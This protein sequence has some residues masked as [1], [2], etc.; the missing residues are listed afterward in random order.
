MG[1]K[2]T[3][4]GRVFF[5]S[6]N[7]NDAPKGASLPQGEIQNEIVGLL[8]ALNEKLQA[9]QAERDEIRAELAAQRTKVNQLS[10]KTAYDQEEIS[11]RIHRFEEL[12][13]RQATLEKM[14]LEHQQ[15]LAN[16]SAH[17]VKI[18]RRLEETEQKQDA[19]LVRMEDA[20]AEQARLVRQ[21]DKAVQ[22]RSRMLRKMERIEE[23]VLQTRDA[24]NAGTLRM[25]PDPA[26]PQQAGAADAGMRLNALLGPDPFRHPGSQE[27]KQPHKWWQSGGPQKAAG[28]T[29]LLLGGVLLGWLISDAQMPKMPKFD[30]GIFESLS[31]DESKWEPVLPQ[32]EPLQETALREDVTPAEV[33][34]PQSGAE[35]LATDEDMPEETPA[36]EMS[37]DIAEGEI[38]TEAGPDEAAEDTPDTT[39]LSELAKNPDDELANDIGAIDLKD[40]ASLLAAMENDPEA[41]AAR[42]NEIEPTSLPEREAADVMS[43]AAAKPAPAK[44][45]Q[46]APAVKSSLT[47]LMP[48]DGTLPKVIKDIERQAYEGNAEA[49]H[50][51]AA[52]YTAGHGGVK[53]DYKRAAFWFE[54]A[55]KGGVANARYNLGVLYH[56]GIGVPRDLERALDW[57]KSAADLNHP[58]AQYNL[59]IAYIEGIGLEYDPEK[60]AW[61]F[62]N[63][64][65]A[66]IMEAAYN[67]GL[68]Y[69]NGLLGKAKPDEALMWYK[70]AADAGSPEA[71]A[72]LAQLAKSLNMK[73]EDVNG[74]VEKVEK[75]KNTRGQLDEEKPV[76]SAQAS[77]PPKVPPVSSAEREYRDMVVQVQQFLMGAGLFPGPAD[78]VNGPLTQDAVRAY[79]LENDLN[80]T[81]EVNQDLLVHMKGAPAAPVEEDSL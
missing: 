21:I 67:L 2:R 5:E 57:Y 59:G 31:L 18:S 45:A 42:L 44:E 24:I 13:K 48:A 10:Q 55:A 81:G 4:E 49:Q 9:T 25:L 65:D 38:V 23:T 28:I 78:G 16:H 15:K 69:E 62:E 20:T 46:T 58:E 71:K 37:E 47:A 70:R 56:Q 53:Q 52:I 76:S 19:L 79:Q 39:G 14:Q 50:D 43:P 60:A 73:V 27:E 66:G 68:I 51:L 40:E 1:F 29:A 7:T 34:E 36:G 75:L 80:V 72:A 35:F 12:G 63:A 77:V 74:L 17:A 41:L 64:A 26:G 6:A 33:V 8:K 54:Q 32:Q 30:D 61:Y 22:D 3:T 11:D